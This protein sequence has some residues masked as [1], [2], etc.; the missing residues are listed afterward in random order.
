MT[1]ADIRLR[2]DLPGAGTWRS[3]PFPFRNLEIASSLLSSQRRIQAVIMLVL[4]DL[5]SKLSE[6]GGEVFLRLQIDFLPNAVT[7][8]IDRSGLDIHDFGYVLG[9]QV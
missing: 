9:Y 3:L 8:N 2:E 1:F 7:V 4:I 6:I 5:V